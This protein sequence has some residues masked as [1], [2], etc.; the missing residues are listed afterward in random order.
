MDSVSMKQGDRKQE[1]IK[2]IDNGIQ[3]GFLKKADDVRKMADQEKK[4][5]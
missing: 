4:E 3:A 1:W 5:S 2:V